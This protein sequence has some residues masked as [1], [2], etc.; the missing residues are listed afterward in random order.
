MFRSPETAKSEEPLKPGG[1]TDQVDHNEPSGK[2]IVIETIEKTDTAKIPLS[3]G[4]NKENSEVS[5][6][7]LVEETEQTVKTESEESFL[8]NSTEKS[9]FHVKEAELGEPVVLLEESI[10]TVTDKAGP[11]SASEPKGMFGISRLTAPKFGF[12]SVAAD[13]TTTIGS[14]FSPTPS[15]A[16]GVKATQSQQA[17]GGI[18]SGFKNLSAG[19]FQ[20]ETTR[21]EEPTTAVFSMKLASI[22]GSSD[23]PK[24][25]SYPPVIT[26]QPQSQGP[27]PTDE[28]CEPESKKLSPGSEKP[29]SANT[30]D[31][32]EPTETS[33]TGSCDT[34][35]QSG[36]P[37]DSVS[38]AESP[39]S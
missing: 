7:D 17:D 29:G 11:F 26:A 2:E 25:E 19:I 9:D 10:S 1:E 31:M 33:Q 13:D 15:L 37:S 12:M 8:N 6:K 21:K 38:L 18:L 30:S 24:P 16:P 20:D 39:E 35:A 5:A 28:I 22:F 34:T 23:S 27:K 4:H 32:E 14:L 36:L 3:E